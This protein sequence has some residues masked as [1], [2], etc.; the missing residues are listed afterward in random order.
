MCECVELKMCNVLLHRT[1]KLSW[2]VWKK[3]VTCW[4]VNLQNI[5]FRKINSVRQSTTI[6]E[7]LLCCFFFCI[8]TK[9][10]LN[11]KLHFFHFFFTFH[12]NYLDWNKLIHFW[13]RCFRGCSL[14]LP[15]RSI[16]FSFCFLNSANSLHRIVIIKSI[17]FRTYILPVLIEGVQKKTLCCYFHCT[18][19]SYHW[20]LHIATQTTEKGVV[21]T[22]E[23]E[24][25]LEFKPCN[26]L[27][28]IF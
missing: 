28:M 26:N 16:F 2:Y 8:R 23:L 11:N 24:I 19:C 5:Q 15:K 17:V 14:T 25:V 7:K 12:F 18:K 22:A 21:H 20:W 9:W 3:N 4:S 10:K 1:I 6:G 13:K 27:K